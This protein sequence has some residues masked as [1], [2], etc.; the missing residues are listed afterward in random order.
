MEE[1]FALLKSRLGRPSRRGVSRNMV[2]LHAV[3]ELC[4]RPSRRG[5]SRN[6]RMFKRRLNAADVAPPA[7]A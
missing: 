5:V 6:K 3:A 4:S 1:V 7:G 2:P